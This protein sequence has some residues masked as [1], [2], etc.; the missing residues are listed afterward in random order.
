MRRPRAEQEDIGPKPVRRP[1]AKQED[2]GPKLAM[3]HHTGKDYIGTC[4]IACKANSRVIHVQFMWSFSCLCSPTG[5]ATTSTVSATILSQTIPD[6]LTAPQEDDDNLGYFY[7]LNRSILFP[8]EDERLPQQRKARADEQRGGE[9][10][11]SG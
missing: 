3:R 9:G 10:Y 4:K 7:L 5:A 6:S 11:K 8:T 1:R 2:I